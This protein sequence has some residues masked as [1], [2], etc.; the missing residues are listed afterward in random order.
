MA[1]GI[2]EMQLRVWAQGAQET[3]SGKDSAGGVGGIAKDLGNARTVTAQVKRLKE[4][5]ETLEGNRR[6]VEMKLKQLSDGRTSH[7]EEMKLL[8]EID[9]LAAASMQEAQA[10]VIKAREFD[11]HCGE[12]ARQLLTS[13]RKYSEAMEELRQQAKRQTRAAR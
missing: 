10:A 2:K 4:S 9:S 5:F 8:R 1:N 12:M 3:V 7:T 13:T 6:Q 11:E